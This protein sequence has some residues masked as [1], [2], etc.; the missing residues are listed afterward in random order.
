MMRMRN[1]AILI[2]PHVWSCQNDFYWNL[3]I[4]FSPSQYDTKKTT[5]N[6]LNGSFL[7]VTLK[8]I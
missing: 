7:S 6:I 2:G 8:Y 3:L 5:V 4:F 1:T